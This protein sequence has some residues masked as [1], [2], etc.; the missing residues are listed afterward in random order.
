M[1]D[2][3]CNDCLIGYLHWFLRRMCLAICIAIFVEAFDYTVSVNFHQNPGNGGQAG[4]LLFGD[5]Y[6]R[7]QTEQTNMKQTQCL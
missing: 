4:R 7:L 2:D 1:V 3:R 6:V 5:T